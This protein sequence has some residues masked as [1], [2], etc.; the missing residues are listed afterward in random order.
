MEISNIHYGLLKMISVIDDNDS[1]RI[2]N[3]ILVYILGICTGVFIIL[4][5]NYFASHPKKKKK[6][7]KN[8]AHNQM[9][10]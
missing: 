4:L 2:E 8:F 9:T 7:N 3:S 6:K 1:K 10:P 5:F